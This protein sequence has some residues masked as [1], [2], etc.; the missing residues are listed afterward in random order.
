MVTLILFHL[1]VPGH[2]DPLHIDPPRLLFS[3]YIHP[4]RFIRKNCITCTPWME[5]NCATVIC[6]RIA[7]TLSTECLGN[8]Y[9]KSFVYIRNPSCAREFASVYGVYL[10]L[11]ALFSHFFIPAYL[12][13]YSPRVELDPPSPGPLKNFFPSLYSYEA[14]WNR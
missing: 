8:Q 9:S 1:Q 7:A 14:A 4:A 6:L 13:N 2:P 5:M 12:E 3:I 11:F 10:C